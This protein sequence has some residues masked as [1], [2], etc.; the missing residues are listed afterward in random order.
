MR[1]D[2]FDRYA[3]DEKQRRNNDALLSA[4]NQIGQLLYF[5]PGSPSGVFV[6]TDVNGNPAAALYIRTDGDATHTLY[7]YSPSAA[8]WTAK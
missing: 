2:L 5:G 1:F 3:A 8:A 7:V 6:P 4:V